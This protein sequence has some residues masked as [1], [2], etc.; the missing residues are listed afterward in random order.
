MNKI[1]SIKNL[2]FR[3][4]KQ[5][6]LFKRFNLTIHTGCINGLLGINGEGKTTLI[7]LIAGLLFPIDG[8]VYVKNFETKKRSPKMLQDIFLLPEEIQETDLNINTYQAIYAPFYPKFSVTQFRTYLNDFAIDT[9]VPGIST[10]SYGQK[11]KFHIAFGLATNANLIL[12]DEP[13]NG[14]DIPS[15]RQF[16][17]MIAAAVTPG[18]SIVIS[19][20]QVNDLEDMVDN[21]IILDRHEI[22]FNQLTETIVNKLHFSTQSAY[23]SDKEILYSEQGTEGYQTIRENK[24]GEKSKLDLELLF[25]AVISDHHRIREL[26]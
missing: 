5:E 8:D 17:R 11:K 18:S 10:L 23:D 1:V 6:E 16:R 20:H 12:L 4:K 14:L 26:F 3:Y 7:K 9:G 25:N 24:L 19:T 21:V 15:K 13:T 2:E 22:I